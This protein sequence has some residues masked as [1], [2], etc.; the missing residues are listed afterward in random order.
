MVA[1]LTPAANASATLPVTVTAS[2]TPPIWSFASSVTVPADV[3]SVFC[4]P[5]IATDVPF[6]RRGTYDERRV[7]LVPGLDE[8]LPDKG[9]VAIRILL[10]TARLGR[11]QGL[12]STIRRNGLSVAGGELREGWIN[13]SP[14]PASETGRHASELDERGRARDQTIFD[15]ESASNGAVTGARIAPY[16]MRVT[17]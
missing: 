9:G 14:P 2:A 3:T 11:L 13:P 7:E 10:V 12:E 8:R 16:V 17:P 1:A 5:G 6:A 4:W 15:L